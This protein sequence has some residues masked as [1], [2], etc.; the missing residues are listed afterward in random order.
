MRFLLATAA[1]AVFLSACATPPTG[2]N[3]AANGESDR[4]IC[5]PITTT[6]SNRV[7]RMCTTPRQWENLDEQVKA[8]QEKQGDKGEQDLNRLRA[9]NLPP[10]G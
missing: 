8:A 10:G 4:Q 2:A 5:R 3:L 9:P 6:G 7:T 1:S